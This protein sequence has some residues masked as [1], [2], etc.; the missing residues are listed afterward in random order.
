MDVCLLCL[1]VVL[2]CVG[3]GLCDELIT[4]PEKSC[5]VSNCMC[6]ITENPKGTLCS[7]WEPTG[8]WMNWNKSIT[9]L[10]DWSREF[11]ERQKSKHSYYKPVTWFQVSKFTSWTSWR[12]DSSHSYQEV[13][14]PEISCPHSMTFSWF[15]HF[16]KVHQT[17]LTIV[18]AQSYGRKHE[19]REAKRL[20][21]FA[22]RSIFVLTCKWFFY[23]PNILRHRAYGFTPS[24]K[25]CVLWIFI[26]L[27]NPPPLQ[28]LNLRTLGLMANTL[29]ITPPIR[30]RPV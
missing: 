10:W 11:G 5:R 28:G 4:C 30:F 24:P 29:T 18:L 12:G 3:R 16:L 19:E 15:F 1:Y 9:N 27:K 7:R 14:A 26:S 8:K 25:E 20:K 21:N 23:T 6:V 17:S 13:A 22:L 2:S